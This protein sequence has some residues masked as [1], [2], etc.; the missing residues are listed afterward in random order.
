MPPRAGLDRRR[1][2]VT[3]E[4]A[5]IGV[6]GF[7]LETFLAS[8]AGAGVDCVVDVRQRRG[9][10]GAEYAWANARRLEREL[11]DAEIAYQHHREL[12]PT[13]EM[14]QLQ[15]AAD[16]REGWASGHGS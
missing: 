5:T 13:T 11:T 14:R 6:Y 4:I 12:A 3:V 9:V 7:T 10:R 1:D 15:Y 2:V 16:D 8:L